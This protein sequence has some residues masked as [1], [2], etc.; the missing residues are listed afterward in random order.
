MEINPALLEA[1]ASAGELHPGERSPGR[2]ECRLPAGQDE[3]L[4]LLAEAM[5]GD[6]S[7]RS[8]AARHVLAAGFAALA[9]QYARKAAR[10]E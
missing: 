7:K 2:L 10:A 8:V 6:K 3:A 5:S 9:R 1:L 4:S